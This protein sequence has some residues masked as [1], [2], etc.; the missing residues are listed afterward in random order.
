MER[1]LLETRYQVF[2]NRQN[3][4]ID[5]IIMLDRNLL[6]THARNNRGFLHKSRQEGGYYR[7]TSLIT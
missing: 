4:G 3:L 7:L 6:R 1:I 5:W 2:G